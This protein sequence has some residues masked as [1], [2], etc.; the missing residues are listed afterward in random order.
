MV[1]IRQGAGGDEGA[2]FA[3]DLFRMYQRYVEQRGWSME[4]I[5][6]N[7]GTAGGFKE[8]A[9]EVGGEGVYGILKYD[10]VHRVQRMPQ[11]KA[12]AESILQQHL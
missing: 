9:F 7:E 12:R 10:G 1:E 6:V 3:G 8:I 11:P 2:I 4:V 5:T